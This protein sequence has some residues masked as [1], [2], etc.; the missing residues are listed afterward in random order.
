MTVLEAAEVGF[1]ASGRNVG[2]VNAGMWVMPEVVEAALAPP[3]ADRLL[4]LLGAAPRYVFDLT[5]KY[6][7][8]CEAVHAGTLHC[9]TGSREISELRQRYSQWA[10][11]G[12][13]VRLLTAE[14]TAER[15]GSRKFDAALLDLRAGT[16]QPL[17]YA[18][19]LAQAAMDLGARIFTQSPAVRSER[20]RRG[21]TVH[22]TNGS[23]TSEWVVV[24]TDAYSQG[25]W[26]VVRSSQIHLPY[27]NF[28]TA[29]LAPEVRAAVLPNR[30][31]AWDARLI[32]S[33]FRLDSAGRLIFGSVGALEGVGRRVH[34]TWARRALRSLYPQL[35]TIDFEYG[36]YGNIGLTRDHLPRFHE[37]EPNVVAFCGYNGRGIAPGTAFGR[38][39]ADYVSGAS[40]HHSLPLPASR[41]SEPALRTIREW[42]YRAGSE[43]VHGMAARFQALS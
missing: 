7:I 27:F 23:V 9:G 33:S 18:R 37:L 3:Y 35:G 42:M 30:E 13:P 12:A 4:D 16:I 8:Q 5:A 11:R 14:E 26:N 29:P 38:V 19:G 36:W 1:G 6:R 43:A 25:P 2:L 31:G 32:L 20:G 10:A 41:A 15:T 22:T 40:D 39:I 28:A 21:W 17:A 34:E 24:A